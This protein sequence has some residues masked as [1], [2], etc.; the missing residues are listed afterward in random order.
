MLVDTPGV[1]PFGNRDEIRLGLVSGISPSKLENPDLVSFELIK[2]FQKQNPNALKNVYNIDP[3][4]YPE[5]ILNQ[6]AL[7]KNMLMKKGIPDERRAAIQF[8][9]DWHSGKIKI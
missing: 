9:S 2:I 7:K 8:L 1:V 5:E 3:N 6:I 4:S